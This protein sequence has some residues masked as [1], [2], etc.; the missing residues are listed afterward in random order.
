[1]NNN[2]ERMTMKDRIIQEWHECK[3][4]VGLTFGFIGYVC[5]VFYVG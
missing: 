3:W 5:K 1:M 2:S 4:I